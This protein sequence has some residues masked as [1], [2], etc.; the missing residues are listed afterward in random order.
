M[1][2]CVQIM[3]GNMGRM[4]NLNGTNWMTWKN[5]MEDLLYCKDIYGPIEGIKAKLEG[6]FDAN[7]NKLDR[8]TVGII[9][10]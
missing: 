9:R 8:K 2:I 1:Q 6:T 7:W 4:V 10:Q 3:G 5:K